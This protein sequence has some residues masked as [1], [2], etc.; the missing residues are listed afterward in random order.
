M[1]TAPCWNR[2]PML[3]VSVR[4]DLI[5]ALLSL[6][7]SPLLPSFS[8]TA[9]AHASPF[10]SGPHRSSRTPPPHRRTASSSP[11]TPPASSNRPPVHVPEPAVPHRSPHTPSS[12][13][14][15]AP[16]AGSTPYDRSTAAPDS[17]VPP[18]SSTPETDPTA[19]AWPARPQRHAGPDDTHLC[20]SAFH[21]PSPHTAHNPTPPLP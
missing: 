11:D 18:S 4:T 21:P 13:T 14:L 7:S 16:P 9:P 2:E 12:Q 3:P 10:P 17:R 15:A 5:F 20:D 6:F 19:T 1:V 8:S